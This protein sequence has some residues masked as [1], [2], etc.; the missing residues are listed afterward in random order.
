MEPS[1]QIANVPFSGALAQRNARSG[2]VKTYPNDDPRA[3][4]SET[5]KSVQI[6]QEAEENWQETTCRFGV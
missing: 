5:I 3:G 2:E 6:M 1:G 4:Q